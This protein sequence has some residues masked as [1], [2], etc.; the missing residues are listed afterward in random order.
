MDMI[1]LYTGVM[2]A[3]MAQGLENTSAMLGLKL[4]TLHDS[5][6]T[7]PNSSHT[8]LLTILNVSRKQ[9]KR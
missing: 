8:P 7:H 4:P 2:S 6:A 3:E 9:E 1:G 5:Q